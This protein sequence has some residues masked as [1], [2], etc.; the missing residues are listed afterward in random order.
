[1][2]K[3][4]LRGCTNLTSIP[5]DTYSGL[6]PMVSFISSFEGC[7]SLSG[8]VPEFWV[9]FPTADGTDCFRNDVS[10]TNY[11]DIPVSWGGPPPPMVFDINVTVSGTT[12]QLPLEDNSNTEVY[13]FSVLWGDGSINAVT[14][15]S[16]TR[17]S[18]TYDVGT[19][20]VKIYGTCQKFNT[21]AALGSSLK[22]LLT[23]VVSWGLTNCYY[24]NFGGCYNLT[25]IPTD[26][27]GSWSNIEWLAEVFIGC[28]SLIS[29]PSGLFDN[30]TKSS[31][32]TVEQMFANCTSLTFIPYG[33]FD[34]LI[35]LTDFY[36][37]FKNCASLITIPSGLFD[38][39]ILVNNF[40]STFYN[41][42][43]GNFGGIKTIPDDLFKY[44][45]NVIYMYDCFLYATELT[46]IPSGLFDTLINVT[47]FQDCF[48]WCWNLTSLPT[49]LFDNCV[50]VNNFEYTF[51]G[52]ISLSGYTDSIWL[53][54]PSASGT[55]CFQYDSGL[56]NW[57]YI[58]V[59]WGGPPLPILTGSTV[60]DS[61][62]NLSWNYSYINNEIIEI[63]YSFD[64]IVY[65]LVDTVDS[66]TTTHTIYSLEH[67]TIYY[68]KIRNYNGTLYSEF[69]NV[70]S[71]QTDPWIFDG[72]V[73]YY[74]CDTI[75]GTIVYDN[76]GNN[77]LTN[78][79]G[80]L[81]TG[82]INNSIDL[83]GNK[84]LDGTST[85]FSYEKTNSFSISLW[86]YGWFG[87]NTTYGILNKFLSGFNKGYT[88]YYGNNQIYMVFWDGNNGELKVSTT[89]NYIYSN[90][91]GIDNKWNNVVFTYDGSNTNNG[92]KIY[93]NNVLIPLIYYGNNLNGSI[94]NTAPFRI[95]YEGWN[96]YLNKKI[97]EI[98]MFDKVVAPK[99]I[100]LIWNNGSGRTIT[101]QDISLEI[102][103]VS[104]NTVNLSWDYVN[105][106]L[107]YVTVK[108]SIDSVNFTTVAITESGATSYQVSGLTN[109]TLYYFKV[110]TS[111]GS[112]KSNIVSG[113]TL[114][115]ISLTTNSISLNEVELNWSFNDVTPGYVHIEISTDEMNYTDIYTTSSGATYYLVSGLTMNT[116]Y[117]FR[118]RSSGTTYSNYSNVSSSL[119]WQYVHIETVTPNTG[120]YI[121]NFPL[122]ITVSNTN[123]TDNFYVV[124][125]C[126]GYTNYSFTGTTTGITH[127]NSYTWTYTNSFSDLGNKVINIKLYDDSNV[128]WDEVNHNVDVIYIPAN[129]RI[130]S[131]TI[132]AGSC[133]INVTNIGQLTAYQV[134]VNNIINAYAFTYLGHAYQTT[135]YSSMSYT[136]IAPGGSATI[137]VSYGIHAY[138]S[139]T[140]GTN[141]VGVS[142]TARVYYS[143]SMAPSWHSNSTSDNVYIYGGVE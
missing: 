37:T 102:D 8:Y 128:L 89:Y 5:V 26:T 13:N 6:T 35:Y 27:L 44:N 80:V 83:N 73:S 119:T 98:G 39:N 32:I 53:D 132:G 9:D 12:L 45:V 23:K 71:G 74:K 88:I 140:T 4:N 41:Y 46:S 106:P 24:F 18:H 15:Y 142:V 93:F 134:H 70:F 138:R 110:F 69:S 29:I 48:S 66:G 49:G 11:W 21:S 126:S 118:V 107:D 56:T 113:Y 84:T 97:D 1:M 104:F 59:S 14:G 79:G 31:V 117:Y 92:M 10:V 111:S 51:N 38:K 30:I 54:F 96:S 115:D 108:K 94:V 20:Q 137:S 34:N 109:N 130:N 17:A 121:T 77:D 136:N 43:D 58:P 42:N 127:G 86:I 100:D 105:N 131:R 78:N 75:D 116:L 122:N 50:N 87:Y 67:N 114:Q 64:D 62:I 61:S 91:T 72:L 120:Y 63:Y 95:G 129:I 47:S 2:Y 22:P 143:D 135:P 124:V 25:E 60:D 19:Y 139:A 40:N 33:L 16:D 103:S 3:I 28:S 82:L 65:G 133:S 125:S 68:F 85:M 36:A 99:Q 57:E 76:I 141:P 52:N 123:I 101:L 81:T 7:T 55:G 90:F 112:T